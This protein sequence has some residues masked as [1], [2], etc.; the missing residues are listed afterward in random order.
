[1]ATPDGADVTAQDAVASARR[2]VEAVWRIESAR[3]VATLTRVVGDFGLAEDLAQEALLLALAQWPRDGVPPNPGAWLTTVA[4]RKAIDM[5]RRN[6][7]LDD[8]HADMAHHLAEQ[9]RLDTGSDELPWDP[10]TIDDD[11]LRLVFTACHPILP[12]ESQIA[13]TLRVVGGLT[14]EEIA[15]AFMIP[16]ATVQQRVVRAKKT[17]AAAEIPFE[18]PPR[19]EFD[20]RL[21]SVLSVAYLI[22]NEGY[23]ATSGTAWTRPDL[24][25]EA[26]RLTRI[27]SALVPEEPEVLALLALLELQASRFAARVDANGE[28]ILLA[29]QDRSRWDHHQI[30]RGCEALARADAAGRG[31]GAYALQAG[32]AEC[33]AVAASTAETDWAQ[34][35]ALYDALGSLA[36]SPVVDLNRAVAVAMADGP[37]AGLQLVDELIAKRALDG[38][39]LLPSVR[40]ELLSRLERHDEARIEFLAAAELT[41]NER[42]RAVLVEKA[43]VRPSA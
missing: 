13:L 42:E 22:F 24:A 9:Q 39:S 33:H 4:K 6:N 19:K 17:I 26:I 36:P 10:E 1:M 11:V 27:L 43:G 7:R 25:N 14:S 38:Y 20:S 21:G 30:R 31:R 3:I 35:V 40:G 16:V 5:H 32:I 29:D 15:R 28:P 34:I 12:R 18:V 8:R 41:H 2:R 37:A 23:A